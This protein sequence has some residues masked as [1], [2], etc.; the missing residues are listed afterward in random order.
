VH[1][2]ACM[3]VRVYTN[4]HMLIYTR[5]RAPTG[6]YVNVVLWRVERRRI[7]TYIHIQICKYTHIHIYTFTHTHIYTCTCMYTYTHSHTHICTYTHKTYTHTHIHTYS[8]THVNTY[9]ASTGRYRRCSI[10]AH[11]RRGAMVRGSRAVAAF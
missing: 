8:F 7:Y 1:V 4:T 2:C 5:Y 3:R 10:T 11:G 9:R 6:H